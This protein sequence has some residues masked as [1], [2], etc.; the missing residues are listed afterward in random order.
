MKIDSVIAF[1][2]D[3]NTERIL[4]LVPNKIVTESSINSSSNTSGSRTSKSSNKPNV[5]EIGI[6]RIESFRY[7]SSDDS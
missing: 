5:I 3:F 6:S 2:P 4:L 7:E 1:P